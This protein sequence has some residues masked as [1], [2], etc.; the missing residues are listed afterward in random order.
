MRAGGHPGEKWDEDIRVKTPVSGATAVGMPRTA[1][2]R[3][4]PTEAIS[5]YKLY[6]GLSVPDIRV[7]AKCSS[8]YVARTID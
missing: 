1:R 6:A 7:P 8:R 5:G 3:M 4:H 2:I